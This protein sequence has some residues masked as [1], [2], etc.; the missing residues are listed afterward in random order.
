[1]RL[2]TLQREHR[3]TA[4]SILIFDQRGPRTL[5]EANRKPA[6]VP[7]VG[8]LD[9]ETIRPERRQLR[10]RR[11]VRRLVRQDF[12]VVLAC[13]ERKRDP[14]DV[15]TLAG[16]LLQCL[17]CWRFGLGQL[18]PRGL[19]A[20]AGLLLTL[21]RKALQRTITFLDAHDKPLIVSS[22]LSRT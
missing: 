4:A 11:D 21:A 14:T 16:K 18:L 6:D 19:I 17:Q 5:A 7:A 13:T 2:P 15:I 12:L 22:E 9:Q 10:T 1:E 8:V 3:S 20:L